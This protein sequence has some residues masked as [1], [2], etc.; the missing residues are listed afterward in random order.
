M[1]GTDRSRSLLLVS[2]FYPPT[3]DTGAQRP[4]AMAKWL[5]RSGWDV[6]VL[7]TSAFTPWQSEPAMPSDRYRL[8]AVALQE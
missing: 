5:A 7:T 3:R 1:S 6:T 8:A 4:A 2:Y